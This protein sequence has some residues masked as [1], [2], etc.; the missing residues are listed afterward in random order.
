MTERAH[1]YRQRAGGARESEHNGDREAELAT[2][3]FL[4]QWVPA[5]NRRF[6]VTASARIVASCL[7]TCRAG[8]LLP[9]PLSRCQHAERAGRRW[10][11]EIL[12]GF[13]KQGTHQAMM[14]SVSRWRSWLTTASILSSLK[15]FLVT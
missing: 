12:D 11:P 1:P 6:A 4:K 5:G 7:N 3:E 15:F 8:S 10:K 9:L 13:T 14:I 2:L